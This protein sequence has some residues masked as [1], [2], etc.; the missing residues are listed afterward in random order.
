[1][2]TTG[3]SVLTTLGRGKFSFR[4][5]QS[6]LIGEVETA[7]DV[8]ELVVQ[9]R[10]LAPQERGQ[11]I[12]ISLEYQSADGVWRRDAETVVGHQSDGSELAAMFHVAKG[13]PRVRLVL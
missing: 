4:G 3:G 5:A 8:T 2:W 12:R 7:N 9:G 11:F 1:E 6:S 13:S 10:W